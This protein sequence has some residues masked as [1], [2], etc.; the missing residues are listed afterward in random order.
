MSPVVTQMIP[1]S[2][3]IL[4][5]S[6]HFLQD[7][8]PLTGST[9]LFK[10]VDCFFSL[11]R[12]G[13]NSP[14]STPI[15]LLLYT[16][17]PASALRSSKAPPDNLPYS[18]QVPSP[19]LSCSPPV[20]QRLSRRTPL[21]SPPNGTKNPLPPRFPPPTFHIL[22]PLSIPWCE[23]SPP[24]PPPPKFS[25]GTFGGRVPVVSQFPP[26]FLASYTVTQPFFRKTY[27]V[28]GPRAP[29]GFLSLSSP[30]PFVP[31]PSS[32]SYQRDFF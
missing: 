23:Q 15:F 1:F 6:Q 26:L 16:K 18:F 19:S 2:P 22:S 13:L 31:L 10:D 21:H 17:N 29:F 12:L 30:L 5:Y 20:Y 11:L 4:F 14:D 7:P 24:T 27:I 8:T 9:F 28:A 3:L 25:H 32:P